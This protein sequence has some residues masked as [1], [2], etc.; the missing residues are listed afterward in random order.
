MKQVEVFV[1]KPVQ[2]VWL[3]GFTFGTSRKI[4]WNFLLFFNQH[5]RRHRRSFHRPLGFSTVLFFRKTKL[6]L[7]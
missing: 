4:E 1:M 6:A 3:S 7:I 2:E 5:G